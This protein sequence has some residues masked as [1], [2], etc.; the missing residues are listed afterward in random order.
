MLTLAE[1]PDTFYLRI[2]KPE[3]EEQLRKKDILVTWSIGRDRGFYWEYLRH[4][5]FERPTLAS[6]WTLKESYKITMTHSLHAL[7]ESTLEWE[8]WQE[9][10][11]AHDHPAPEQRL[12][13]DRRR[14]FQILLGWRMKRMAQPKSVQEAVDALRQRVGGSISQLASRVGVNH[15]SLYYSTAGVRGLAGSTMIKLARLADQL[16]EW[17]CADVLRSNA[18]VASLNV[19]RR[20]GKR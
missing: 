17:R 8:V 19:N 11:D 6:E 3:E 12:P 7:I 1:Q 10:Y 5:F 16:M 20:G 9:F 18:M 2:Q 4:E 13:I 14:L 15:T